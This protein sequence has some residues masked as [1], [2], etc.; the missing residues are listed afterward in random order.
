MPI[1]ILLC[2]VRKS[3]RKG[4]DVLPQR[5][6]DKVKIKDDVNIIPSRY[7]LSHSDLHRQCDRLLQPHPIQSGG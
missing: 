6:H 1:I 2:H 4:G 5:K 7:T 3:F